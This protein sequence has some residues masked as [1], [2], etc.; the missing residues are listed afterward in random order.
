MNA[1]TAFKAYK[2][3]RA[4]LASMIGFG[5]LLAGILNA[6]SG[7]L[8][9]YLLLF[10]FAQGM[11]LLVVRRV[12]Q[13]E[14]DAHFEDLVARRRT[15]LD[16]KAS[17]EGPVMGGRCTLCDERIVVEHDGLEPVHCD[18]AQGHRARSHRNATGAYR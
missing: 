11:A 8:A 3:F 1:W 4:A 7:D 2:Y 13:A 15:Q 16:E 9:W 17:R 10:L 6:R 12:R 5:I 14:D 18:C